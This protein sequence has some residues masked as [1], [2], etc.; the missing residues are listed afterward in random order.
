[1]QY[2][3]ALTITESQI[4]DLGDYLESGDNISELVNDVGYLTEADLPPS[5]LQDLQSVMEQGSIATFINPTEPL[6]GLVGF[7]FLGEEGVI[8][9]YSSVTS[10]N[11]TSNK[12]VSAKVDNG[13]TEGQVTAEL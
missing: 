3:T 1:T 5:E 13:E 7:L 10:G 8:Q 6:P 11:F 12:Q 9:D 4:S 2:E